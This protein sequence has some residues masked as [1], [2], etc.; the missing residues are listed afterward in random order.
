MAFPLYCRPA[1][2]SNCGM[3]RW[4]SDRWFD[5]WFLQ[6]LLCPSPKTG[7][8]VWSGNWPCSYKHC[9]YIPML[10]G[11]CSFGRMAR[12]SKWLEVP[13]P[14]PSRRI[15]IDGFSHASRPPGAI[16]NCGGCSHFAL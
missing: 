13:A 1:L 10:R 6:P 8:Q 12:L 15:R 2:R 16:R 9:R 14:C 5:R 7:N 3:P 11:Y 4:C